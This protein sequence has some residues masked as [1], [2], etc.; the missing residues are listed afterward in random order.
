MNRNHLSS[1]IV[2]AIDDV[3]FVVFKEVT[4][5]VRDKKLCCVLTHQI[6]KPDIVIGVVSQTEAVKGID[7]PF[8]QG[9]INKCTQLQQEGK[10]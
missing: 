3:C 1:E 8:W 6:R 9:I 10:L 5:V 4:L 2:S 7:T